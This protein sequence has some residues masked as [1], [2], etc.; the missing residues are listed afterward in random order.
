MIVSRVVAIKFGNS[1]RWMRA[2]RRINNPQNF[3]W[4]RLPLQPRSF[5]RRALITVKLLLIFSQPLYNI[6]GF[7]DGGS[8]TTRQGLDGQQERRRILGKF[9]DKQSVESNFIFA[10]PGRDGRL[11]RWHVPQ[12]YT[13]PEAS[14]RGKEQKGR[15]GDGPV[16]VYGRTKKRDAR[17]AGAQAENESGKKR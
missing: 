9:P 15:G 4:H 3:T 12:V 17:V 8:N 13:W 1:P 2:L 10:C 16:K 11:C 7:F 14:A 6:F 5:L